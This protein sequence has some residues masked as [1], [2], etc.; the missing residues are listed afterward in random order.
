MLYIFLFS[1]RDFVYSFV[2]H[3]ACY[4]SDVHKYS[5]LMKEF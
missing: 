4:E 3:H 5:A 2:F 1:Y